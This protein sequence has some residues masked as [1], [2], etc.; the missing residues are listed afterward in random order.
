MNF[1]DLLK[2]R[3]SYY[4]IGRDIQVSDQKMLETIDAVVYNVPDANN[5]QSQRVVVALGDHQDKLWDTI[6][7]AFGGKVKREKIDSFKNG[8]GTILFYYDKKAVTGM[9][10]KLPRYADNF[11]TWANQANGMLQHSIWLALRDL[12]LGA[13]LQHYNPVID[14]A[15][16]ELFDLSEDWV[17]LA[18]MPFGNIL[19]EPA[20]KDKIDVRERVKVFK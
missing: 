6:Y 5:M 18:Q 19:E 10:E 15:L 1:I 14:D 12:G 9:M 13:S 8:Y 17:L 11:E 7:D 16:R 3:R 20:P 2:K 4:N